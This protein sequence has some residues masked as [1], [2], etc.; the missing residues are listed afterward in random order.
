MPVGKS[1]SGEG[2]LTSR[3]ALSHRQ[4]VERAFALAYFIQRDREAAIRI[5]AGAMQKLEVAASAQDKRLYYLPRGS[6]RTGGAKTGALRTKVS[7]GEPQ[8]LQ[9]LVYIESDLEERRSER[10]PASSR[11]TRADMLLRFIKYLVQVTLK[12]NAFYVNLGIGRILHTYSTAESMRTYDAIMDEEGTMKDEDYFRSR[13]AVLL[14][15]ILGRFGDRL[16]V[17]RRPGGEDR[18]ESRIPSPRCEQFVR[19]CLEAFTPW[20]TSCATPAGKPSPHEAELD[21]IHALIHPVCYQRLTAE[22]ALPSPCTRLEIPQFFLAEKED[23]GGSDA[24]R[25]S[26]PGLTPEEA[27][28]ILGSLADEA[29]RRRGAA[30]GLLQVRVDGREAA[31]LD[32][33]RERRIR[34]EVDPAAELIE[35]RGPGDILLATHLL[36]HDGR[37][38]RSSIVLE[39]GQKLVFEVPG[40]DDR[41]APAATRPLVVRYR[42]A[43]LLSEL[44]GRLRRLRPPPLSLRLAFGAA[45]LVVA[46]AISLLVLHPRENDSGASV[47]LPGPGVRRE[48]PNS[49]PPR[50]APPAPERMASAAGASGDRR[51]EREQTRGLQGSPAGVSLAG[52][53][54]ILVEAVGDAPGTRDLCGRLKERLREDGRLEV[55]ESPEQAEAVLRVR[56]VRSG[57]EVAFSLEV[58]NARGTTLWPSSAPAGKHLFRGPGGRI[59][60]DAV[61]E[62]LR[63][64]EASGQ[65]AR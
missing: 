64:R 34:I 14:R 31:R 15:E 41:A 33:E 1:P 44:S 63:D 19:R 18:L 6:P 38:T 20:A 12:R 61:R 4:L 37:S 23:S 28:G 46:A 40:I 2:E 8:L 35:V 42:P 16:R 22:L 56:A 29:K 25:R 62:L 49:P 57:G 58:V 7:L 11:L 10:D 24:D 32:P 53:R 47:S 26:V 52:V 54:T 3:E 5:A 36:T 59:A 27:D 21:R 9:R 48:A 43:G 60:R 17:H 65:I 13:K 39:G 51:Q 50:V 55:T 30:T 45:L